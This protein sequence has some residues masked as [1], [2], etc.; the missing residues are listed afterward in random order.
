VEYAVSTREGLARFGAF[1]LGICSD[2]TGDNTPDE[3]RNG[4]MVLA[5]A[6]LT[7]LAPGKVHLVEL[8]SHSLMVKLLRKVGSDLWLV[9]NN[10]ENGSWPAEDA[11]QWSARSMGR[12]ATGG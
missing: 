7:D 5:D 1:M 10:P 8:R 12:L 3:I 9:S 4:G 11:L 6:S 2:S